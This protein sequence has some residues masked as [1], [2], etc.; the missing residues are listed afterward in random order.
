MKTKSV[1]RCSLLWL[2]GSMAI[3]CAV[4]D[5]VQVQTLPT[6]DQSLFIERVDISGNRRIPTGTILAQIETKPGTTLNASL[7][8]RDIRTLESLGE[9]DRIRVEEEDGEEGKIVIFHV[10]ERLIIRSIDFEGNISM[11]KSY[12]LERLEDSAVGLRMET[13]FDPAIL[14]RSELFLLDL[15]AERGRQNATVKVETF[16]ILPDAV[17]IIFYID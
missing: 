6:P 3:G 16:V 10:Q 17:G 5:P 7:V 4:R 12:I 8:E 14:R 2:V 1:F 15:L 11:T 9:F 13:P